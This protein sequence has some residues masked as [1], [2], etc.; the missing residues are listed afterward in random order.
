[1]SQCDT[2][3]LELSIKTLVYS[4]PDKKFIDWM[5]ENQS[6]RKD[7]LNGMGMQICAMASTQGDTWSDDQ[8]QKVIFPEM[9]K[10]LQYHPHTPDEVKFSTDDFAKIYNFHQTPMIADVT[11]WVGELTGVSRPNGL[12]TLT[13]KLHQMIHDFFHA[14][15]ATSRKDVE[16]SEFWIEPV[17]EF[18][19][20]DNWLTKNIFNVP[21]P[22]KNGGDVD[23]AKIHV[24][25]PRV[26][27]DFDG[28][29]TR[30]GG[31]VK[32][33]A[34]AVDAGV[35]DFGATVD[36]SY[37]IP[38]ADNKYFSAPQLNEQ[39]V[40]IGFGLANL[41]VNLMANIG[42]YSGIFGELDITQI[43][44][45]DMGCFTG[46]MVNKIDHLNRYR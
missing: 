35:S 32:S 5:N 24:A 29:I 38:A 36:L 44:S 6:F 1:V 22:D 4:G 28:A 16:Y 13:T 39:N 27:F 14:D 19:V 8:W 15:P 34:L 23:N 26:T 7:A 3:D 40:H 41:G 33:Q 30:A 31:E 45:G 18:F 21:N 12:L 37:D 43:L 42:M 25:T 20:G 46:A 17:R 2:G 11:N 10:L 9:A